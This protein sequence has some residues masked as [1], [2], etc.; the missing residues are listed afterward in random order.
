M[1]ITRCLWHL[2]DGMYVSGY[3]PEVDNVSNFLLKRW[4]VLWLE[5]M[6]VWYIYDPIT[7]RY[8]CISSTRCI[9][10]GFSQET[11]M[12][13]RVWVY[14]YPFATVLILRA[15]NILDSLGERALPTPQACERTTFSCKALFTC[16]MGQSN[17]TFKRTYVGQRVQHTGDIGGRGRGR[18]GGRWRWRKVKEMKIQ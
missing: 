9:W 5:N 14:L 16:S 11:A 1:K 7:T 15:S 12:F 2:N 3:M 13:H 10:H 4:N 8:V 18:R 17:H 6:F